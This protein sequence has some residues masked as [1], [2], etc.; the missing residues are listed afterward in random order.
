MIVYKLTNKIN[1]KGYIG[2]TSKTLESRFRGH[3]NHCRKGKI[4]YA[5]HNSLIKYGVDNFDKCTL[6]EGVSWKEIQVV[7]RALIAEYGTYFP[8]GYNLTRGGGGTLGFKHIVGRKMSKEAVKRSAEKRRGQKR[9]DEMKKHISLG[10]IGKG[11]NNKAAASLTKGDVAVIKCLLNL[12]KSQTEIGCLFNI[13][14]SAISKIKTGKHWSD[15]TP[16]SLDQIT[17]REV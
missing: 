7:E 17:G 13:D 15:I 2:I 8:N 12:N 1:G 3:L 16:A 10:R 14:Q 6:Y 4:R 11:L 9:T 5:I